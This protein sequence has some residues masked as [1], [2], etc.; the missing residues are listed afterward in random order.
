MNTACPVAECRSACRQDLWCNYSQ[1]AESSPEDR[2][3]CPAGPSCSQAA[4]RWAAWALMAAGRS[5][6]RERPQRRSGHTDRHRPEADHS[7]VVVRQWAAH[8]AGQWAGR[9][10]AGRGRSI[11]ASPWPAM[12]QS[13]PARNHREQ[14]PDRAVIRPQFNHSPAGRQCQSPERSTGRSEPRRQRHPRG[15]GSRPALGQAQGRGRGPAGRSRNHHQ[16]DQTR[17]AYYNPNSCLALV[18]TAWA[19]VQKSPRLNPRLAL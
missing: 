19:L 5:W 8:Q 15:V 11:E 9:P 2:S 17:T 4:E 18:S 10:A 3:H 14:S 7:W 13:Q 16:K 12:S 6:E 1:E